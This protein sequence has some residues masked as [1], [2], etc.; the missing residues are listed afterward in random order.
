MRTSRAVENYVGILVAVGPIIDQLK[1]VELLSRRQNRKGDLVGAFVKALDV[2]GACL[3]IS[4]GLC[5][6]MMEMSMPVYPEMAVAT[7]TPDSV[8]DSACSVDV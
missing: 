7:V 4:D 6:L 8:A 5:T 1:V 3:Q 2:A